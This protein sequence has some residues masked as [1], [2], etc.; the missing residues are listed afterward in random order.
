MSL[1]GIADGNAV[2]ISRKGNDIIKAPIFRC[3]CFGVIS[4]CALLLIVAEA[5]SADFFRL[6]DIGERVGID[7]FYDLFE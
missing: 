2:A 1:R 3:F 4:L 7:V 6:I 5:E